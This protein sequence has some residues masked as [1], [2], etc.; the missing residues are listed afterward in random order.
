MSARSYDHIVVGSGPGG[1]AVARDLTASGERVLIA[2]WGDEAP[3]TGTFQQAGAE[4]LNPGRSLFV[5]ND[6][7]VLRG[8]TVGGSSIYYYATATEPPYEI[9]DRHGVDLREAIAAARADLPVARFD[10][11]LIGTKATAIQDAAQRL[12][13]DWHPLEKLVYEDRYE[14]NQPM[15]FYG[16][17]VFEAKWNARLWIDEAVD[18]GAELLTGVRVEQVLIEGGRARGVIA[19]DAASGAEIQIQASN[20]ILCAGGL[21]TPRILGASG[22]EGAG[23]DF[24]Y[25]PLTIMAGVVP[26]LDASPEIPMATGL[27]CDEDG[28]VLTDLATPEEV[29]ALNRAVAEVDDVDAPR[30]STLEIMVKIKDDLSGTLAE[31][32]TID[33]GLTAADRAKLEHGCDRAAAILM[34]AG[35]ELIYRGGVSAVHPGGTAKLG[36]VVDADLRTSAENLYVCDASVIPDAWGLPPSLTIVALGKRLA[37]HLTRGAVRH[38]AASMGE[39]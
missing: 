8:V 13:Y 3:V 35:A 36:D 19:A 2:E 25:D 6:V 33:K 37:A 9:F 11:A 7:V 15:G 4:L 23:K 18:D 34:E 30:Q 28:Y 27:R 21:G 26:A 31:D 22:I 32:G 16:A 39:R 1:A 17:P 20:V 5:D 29:F 10:P 24:F 38:A 12:G 14:S